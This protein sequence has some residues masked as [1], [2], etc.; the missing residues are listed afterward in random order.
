[1]K[2]LQSLINIHVNQ[3]VRKMRWEAF[4]A[5]EWGVAFPRLRTAGMKGAYKQ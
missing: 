1:M 4:A 5:V 2:Y 3:K